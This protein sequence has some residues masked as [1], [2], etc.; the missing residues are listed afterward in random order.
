MSTTTVARPA[1]LSPALL[2]PAI[3][4]AVLTVAYV[5]TNA[6]TPHPD[7]S[8]ADVLTYTTAHTGLI[9]AGS[10]L[11]LLSAAP[12]AI[13][14]G[15]IQRQLAGPALT[16]IGGALAAGA[17]TL[18]ALFSWAGARLPASAAPELARALADL[19]FLS[20]GPAYAA[21]FGLLVLG[22]VIPALPQQKLPSWLVWLGIAITVVAA[23]SALGLVA[24]ALT[25]LMPVVRFGGLLWLIT[26]V[27]F[28]SRR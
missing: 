13:L 7:A 9:N 12:L 14:A 5:A 17:L 21:G 10:A 1:R 27:V 28:L 20:G 11:L 3:A 26:T 25:V 19:G 8:G 16:A 2:A 18:S 15:V 6:R 23:V 24:S 4:F 22:I